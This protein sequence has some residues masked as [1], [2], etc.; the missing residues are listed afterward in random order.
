VTLSG[1]GSVRRRWL[2]WLLLLA[3]VLLLAVPALAPLAGTFLVVEEPARPADV[4]FLTY[5][6]LL[7][8]GVDE[9]VRL[10][11]AGYAPRL[12]VSD[13]ELDVAGI[14]ERGRQ[15]L[16]TR[17]LVERGV[18][19]EAITPLPAMPAS[20]E[21]EA[22]LFADLAVREGWGRILVLARDYRMRRTIGT[23]GGALR[24]R[25]DAELIARPI[26]TGGERPGGVDWSRWWTDRVGAGAVLNEWPRLAYY[27][28]LGRF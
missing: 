14:E 3:V 5:S 23:L 4:A 8:A 2:G 10:H 12:V 24:G 28:L 1:I 17:A 11:R 15:A 20:E 7:R 18:P 27:A 13:F 9:A 21:A 16:A 26:P 22:R 6:A 19:P 25:G